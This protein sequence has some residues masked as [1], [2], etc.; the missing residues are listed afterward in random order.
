MFQQPIS[1]LIHDEASSLTLVELINGPVTTLR[2]V[3]AASASALKK[4]YI[5]K[6]LDLAASSIFLMAKQISDAGQQESRLGILGN[7]PADMVDAEAL[8]IPLNE[9]YSKDIS[10][11][12]GIGP[13]TAKLLKKALSVSTIRDL[14][15]WPPYLM[16]LTILNELYGLKDGAGDDPEAPQELVPRTGQLPTEKVQYNVVLF[17]RIFDGRE[18]STPLTIGRKS[19]LGNLG[20]VLKKTASGPLPIEIAGPL[21]ISLTIQESGFSMPALGAILTITQSWFTHG[22]ALGQLLHTVAL[23]PGEST[24]IAMI[25]WSRTEKGNSEDNIGQTEWLD[26]KLDRNRT[27]NEVISAVAKESQSGFSGTVGGG[28]GTG[29]GEGGGGAGAADL[30]SEVGFPLKVGAATGQSLGTGISVGGAA[31]W[32]NSNGERDIDATMTQ[33]VIDSTH[34][35]SSSVRNL[36]ATRVVEVSQSES[37]RVSTRALTNFNHMHALSIQYYEIVQLYRVTVETTRVEACLFIPMKPLNF[38]DAAIRERFKRIIGAAALTPKVEKQT[39]IVINQIAVSSPDRISPWNSRML[40]DLNQLFGV[41]VGKEDD[42][43]LVL[44]LVFYPEK[45]YFRFIKDGSGIGKIESP[46]DALEIEDG[47]GKTKTYDVKRADSLTE[48]GNFSVS[49]GD[50]FKTDS[51]KDSTFWNMKEIR[52]IRT[53]G[54]LDWV[55]TIESSLSVILIKWGPSGT[56]VDSNLQA[57]IQVRANENSSIVF[58]MQ[59]TSSTASQNQD[60]SQDTF[61]EED[62]IEQLVSNSLYYSQ[63]IW[64]SL[65]AATLGMLLSKY[66][67]SGR[68][69]IEIVDPIPV[70]MAGNYLAFRMHGQEQTEWWKK[71]LEDKGLKNRTRREDLIPMPTGGVFGEAV[72]GRFNSAEKLDITRFWNWQDSPIP[73]SAPEIAAINTGSRAQPMDLTTGDLNAPVVTIS[74]PPAI[75]D[76]QGLIAAL[77]ALANGNMFRD[78]SGLAGT[79]G[80]AQAAMQAATQAATTFGEQSSKNEATAADLLAKM[81]GK[82]GVGGAQGTD[83]SKPSPTSPSTISNAGG[84]LNYGEKLDQQNQRNSNTGSGSSGGGAGAGSAD[85]LSNAAKDAYYADLGGYEG[86]SSGKVIPAIYNGSFPFG[87]TGGGGPQI[88]TAGL[89]AQEVKW[90]QDNPEAHIEYDPYPDVLA[91]WNFTVGSAEIAKF[92]PELYRHLGTLERWTNLG[93]T[94]MLTG[95][96]S[97]SGSEASNYSLALN[98]A[99]RV[100][101]WLV[102]EVG[103]PEQLIKVTSDGS[104]KPISGLPIFDPESRARNRRVEI[105]HINREW[106]VSDYDHALEIVRA[107][108]NSNRKTRLLGIIPMLKDG[109][110]DDRFIDQNVANY[111]NQFANLP[112]YE[113]LWEPNQWEG[114]SPPVLLHARESIAGGL[115]PGLS[116]ADIL[117]V[118]LSLDTRILEGI[119][120]VNRQAMSHQEGGMAILLQ[121]L[122]LWLNAQQVNANSIYYYH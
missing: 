96:A 79:I 66:T 80:F 85:G 52:L 33:N 72:L 105:R 17:D 98:R 51:S 36:R 115:H 24:R 41:S 22:L 34:Q 120:W 32:A 73:I 46:F 122:Q 26:S 19:P 49:F 53:K 9:L 10:I 37:E 86:L 78:M 97:I 87:S 90:E 2:G 83:G 57:D 108:P 40:Q 99:S 64:A 82:G 107:E 47:S 68:P 77:T 35:A 30:Q 119:G 89:D 114:K 61:D 71:F 65:D 60:G 55:G 76:P 110:K 48:P 25:D 4:I 69:L 20:D 43:R 106:S 28:L 93:D 84:R 44:P 81:Y 100:K 15:L 109:T 3:S 7:I 88:T 11:L 59:R 103:L 116:D 5:E 75:P 62:F 16:A 8:S 39:Q 23:A 70:S 58:R 42:P 121:K 92:V 101:A 118:F 13:D 27:I 94:V 95:R 67:F 45:I 1:S 111:A 38:R 56:V 21:D 102:N 74:N 14:A 54:K 12:K 18:R 112:G 91:L 29:S 113:W 63:V 31:S 104:S 117:G 6:I 50:E